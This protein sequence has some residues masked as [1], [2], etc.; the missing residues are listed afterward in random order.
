MRKI[1]KSTSLHGTKIFVICNIADEKQFFKT[2]R[3]AKT[4]TPRSNL[5][6]VNVPRIA[7]EEVQS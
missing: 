1:Y 7:V 6:E 5:V 3:C 2:A 4:K